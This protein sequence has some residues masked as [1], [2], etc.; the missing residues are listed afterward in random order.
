MR[1]LSNL[2]WITAVLASLSL[3]APTM[4]EPAA[5][6]AVPTAVD[7]VVLATWWRATDVIGADA[8]TDDRIGKIEALTITSAATIPY[9]VVSVG[10]YLGVD[11]HHV[12]V[13]ASALELVGARLTLHGAA[14]ASLQALPSF[15]FAS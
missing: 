7:P 3:A 5:Q 15:N 14:K 6:T 1:S 8:Y 11:A 2:T 4:A 10:G 12:I 13:A 9:A